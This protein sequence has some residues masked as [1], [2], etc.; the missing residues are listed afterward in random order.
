MKFDIVNDR[1][2]VNGKPVRYVQTKHVG[3]RIEAA[4]VVLH[5]TAGGPPGDSVGCSASAP[6]AITTTRWL[7]RI[8]QLRVEVVVP[9][10]RYGEI[11]IG[12]RAEVRPEAPVGGTHAATVT[13]VDRVLDAASGTFG[14]RLALANPDLAL[15]SGIR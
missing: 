13:V 14:V 10:S 6:C 2:V 8:D 7:A 3:G 15:P 9:T 11:K 4:A 1:L 5:D 12:D